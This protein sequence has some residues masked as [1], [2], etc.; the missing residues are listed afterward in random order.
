MTTLCIG[1]NTFVCLYLFVMHKSNRIPVTCVKCT[2]VCVYGPYVYTH[3]HNIV[4]FVHAWLFMSHSMKI[5]FALSEQSTQPSTQD[6]A[7]LQIPCIQ[8]YQ[9]GGPQAVRSVVCQIETVSMFS[10]YHMQPSIHVKILLQTNVACVQDLLL[11][12]STYVELS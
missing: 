8:I 4:C 1:Y 12:S 10:H 5:R 3:V 2:V 9:W 6:W 11:I 7:T